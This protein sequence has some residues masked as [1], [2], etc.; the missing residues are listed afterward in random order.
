MGICLVDMS[1]KLLPGPPPPLGEPN[2]LKRTSLVCH[3]SI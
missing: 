3:P 2:D 1:S